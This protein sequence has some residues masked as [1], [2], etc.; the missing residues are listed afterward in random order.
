MYGLDELIGCPART[1]LSTT[2]CNLLRSMYACERANLN[3]HCIHKHTRIACQMPVNV[4]GVSHAV[5]ESEAKA[6]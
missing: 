3:R 4:P 5:E 2:C 6:V 1:L